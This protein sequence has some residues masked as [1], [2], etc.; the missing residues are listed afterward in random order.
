MGD[1]TNSKPPVGGMSPTGVIDTAWS[2]LEPLITVQKL[3][4]LHLFGIPLVSFIKDPITKQPQRMNDEI[5]E[6]KINDAVALAEA[7]L[8]MQIFPTQHLEK[9]AFDKNEFQSLG[10]FQLRQRPCSSIERLTVTPANGQDIYEVPVDWVETAYLPRGQI[11]IIPLNIAT[12]G[13][14]FVPA[15]HT[16]GGAFF[17]SILGQR[18]WIA[19]FWQI[20]YTTGWPDGK[21]PRMVNQYIAAIAAIE[22]L[23]LLAATYARSTSHSLG[24]DSMSQSVSTPGPQLFKTRIEELE[25]KRKMLLGKLKSMFGL[26][27]F[28][29]NV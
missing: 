29:N 6:E 16:G 9:Y 8:G 25:A 2:R 4:D 19:A 10:Y 5:V 14:G 24:I 12:V 3:K 18:P 17:L 7:E 27:L 22:I 20:K 1:Y 21:L 11:S 28:S 15:A 23:S 13:G 26:K